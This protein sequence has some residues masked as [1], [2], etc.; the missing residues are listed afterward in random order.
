MSRRSEPLEMGDGAERRSMTRCFWVARPDAALIG[1]TLSTS[2]ISGCWLLPSC[3]KRYAR[4]EI[5][6]AW[7]RAVRVSIGG[8]SRRPV[9]VR[10]ELGE[11][12]VRETVAFALLR[13]H[14]FAL[15][16]GEIAETGRIAALLAGC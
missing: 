3:R 2:W 11:A 13:K 10:C 6:D 12:T 15:V 5:R 1:F 4:H 7:I 9:A 14:L 8:V 16:H